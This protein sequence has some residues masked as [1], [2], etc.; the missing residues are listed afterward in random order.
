[1]KT[2]KTN[3]MK[4]AHLQLEDSFKN[5]KTLVCLLENGSIK[6]SYYTGHSSSGIGQFVGDI[7]CTLPVFKEREDETAEEFKDRLVKLINE[8]TNKKVVREVDVN[9]KF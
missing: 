3:T 5:K 6:Y 9:I 2:I 8:K 4:I 7:G 1:M